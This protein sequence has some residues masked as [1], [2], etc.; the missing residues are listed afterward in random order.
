MHFHSNCKN[1]GA[2][3]EGSKLSFIILFLQP[4]PSPKISVITSE[5]MQTVLFACRCVCMY[6][7]TYFFLVIL[8]FGTFT[9]KYSLDCIN[10]YA[11][12]YIMTLYYV[13]YSSLFFFEGQAGLELLI[14]PSLSRVLEVYATMPSYSL[15]FSLIY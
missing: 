7:H 13:D 11:G 2:Q 4:F 10:A 9:H 6:T 12:F 3:I 5:L 8:E 1:S 14:L 15:L